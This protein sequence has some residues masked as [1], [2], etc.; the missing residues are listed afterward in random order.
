VGASGAI[1]GVMGAYLLLYPFGRVVT[2]IFFFIFIEVVQIPAFF[3]LLLWFM[4]QFFSGA[5][6]IAGSEGGVAWWAHV[7]GFLCGLIL[8]YPFARRK[9]A[10]TWVFRKRRPW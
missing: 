3:F 1:A 10:P 4:L 2:L 8:V 9:R 6:S 5:F 7:G